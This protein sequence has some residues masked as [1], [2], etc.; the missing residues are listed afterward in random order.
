MLRFKPLENISI[1]SNAIQTIPE[2]GIN[3]LRCLKILD[4]NCNRLT[5]L[6]PSLCQLVSLEILTINNNKLVSLPEEIG[7]LE[8]LLQLDVSCNEITHLPIQIGD[9]VSLRSLNIRRNL[10]VELPRE[11][12]KL[13]LVSFDCSSN[14]INKLPLCFRKMVTLIDLTLDN[15]PLELPPAYICTKG[16]LYVMK[17]LL[18]E[19]IKEEKKRGVLS[20]YEI[21]NQMNL[22]SMNNR[23]E[24]KAEKCVT[25]LNI[26]KYHVENVLAQSP[27]ASS[28]TSTASSSNSIS[29]SSLKNAKHKVLPDKQ[30]QN[31]TNSRN[32]SGNFATQLSQT[33]LTTMD[34]Y[35][36]DHISKQSHFFTGKYNKKNKTLYTLYM[37]YI[38]YSGGKTNRS[39][40]KLSDNFNFKNS[41]SYNYNYNYFSKKKRSYNYNYN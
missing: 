12:S 20:E 34:S 23:S 10:L 5:Y 39:K 28:S 15:N 14:R 26:K 7:R 40:L 36:F 8:K 33:N 41:Q 31:I 37:V 24:Y 38:I 35:Q 25:G 19:A 30:N 9:M 4:L 32:R 6:P 17:Y 2:I 1:S 22:L 29:S 3:Q 11:I 21:N 13:K 27:A 16:L 18:V